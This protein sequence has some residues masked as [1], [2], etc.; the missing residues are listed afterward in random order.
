MELQVPYRVTTQNI[1]TA[2]FSIFSSSRSTGIDVIRETVYIA[3]IEDVLDW[4][5]NH[6]RID[7][8]QGSKVLVVAAD[9]AA[10]EQ[11]YEQIHSLLT[12]DVIF[13]TDMAPDIT[14]DT[15]AH[16]HMSDYRV[17]ITTPT[18]VVKQFLTT[19]NQ[20]YTSIVGDTSSFE[21]Q[22]NRIGS[23]HDQITVKTFKVS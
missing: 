18:R 15:V 23:D 5:M 8:Q 19:F 21:S 6:L 11:L 14:P 20:I 22:L 7:I 17:A 12:E 4:Y 10:G 16:G 3:D 13:L 1:M 9:I 2:L